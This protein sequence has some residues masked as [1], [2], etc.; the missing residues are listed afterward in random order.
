MKVS[1]LAI[2]FLVLLTSTVQNEE[3]FE[4]KPLPFAENELLYF[5][6]LPFE[7]L[8]KIK[9]TLN[10]LKNSKN[11]DQ[12]EGNEFE[13]FSESRMNFDTRDSGEK[14]SKQSALRSLDG[15]KI[16]RLIK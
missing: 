12:S 8:L 14:I 16:Q 2:I 15:G 13:S 6:E 11:N 10:D 3:S 1:N 7:E 4:R 9:K 5:A